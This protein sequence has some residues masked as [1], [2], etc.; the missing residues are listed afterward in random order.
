MKLHSTTSDAENSLVIATS[1]E[2]DD[3]AHDLHLESCSELEWI[4]VRTRNSTYDL[5]VV[6]GDTGAVMVRGGQLLKEFVAA[7]VLVDLRG[8]RRPTAH[9]SRRAPSRA[10][11]RRKDVCNV[12]SRTGIPPRNPRFLGTG[13]AASCTNRSWFGRSD[14]P[15]PIQSA[16]CS[17]RAVFRTVAIG[18]DSRVSVGGA[19]QWCRPNHDRFV[20]LAARPVPRKRGL[21]GG[22]PVRLATLQTSFRRDTARD[23]ARREL[24]AVGRR[25]PR[26]SSLRPSQRRIP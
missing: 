19:G 6:S 26:R 12:A 13:L 1:F 17:D 11:S 5:I 24:C 14:P 7:T 2:A 20:Q 3:G 8:Q 18:V 16:S 10:V 9:N 25:C 23:G 15:K 21:R 22:I 4:V